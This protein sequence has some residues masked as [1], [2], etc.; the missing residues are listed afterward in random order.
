M[1]IGAIEKSKKSLFLENKKIE[2]KG[3]GYE[4]TIT[5]SDNRIIFNMKIE[6]NATPTIATITP[7]IIFP[8]F[9]LVRHFLFL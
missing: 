8:I 2:V 3:Y 9:I 4:L 1:E 7:A 6:K 5:S